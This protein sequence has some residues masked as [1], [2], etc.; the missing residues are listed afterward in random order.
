MNFGKIIFSPS[1]ISV[2]SFIQEERFM[3]DKNNH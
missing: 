3:Y 1:I 2:L